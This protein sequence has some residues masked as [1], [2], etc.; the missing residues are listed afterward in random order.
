MCKWLVAAFV[1]GGAA[2][3]LTFPSLVNAA[4]LYF[5]KVFVK[6]NSEST[7]FR[8][9]GD[10]ARLEN[11]QNVHK[12]ALEVAGTKNG[13][14]VSI[15]CVGRGNQPAVAIVMSVADTLEVAKHAADLA[16]NR[17]KG[18]VCFDSPC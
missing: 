11:F 15:T 16:A 13:A 8:F 4:A 17:I 9:A 18:I 7:C 1:A 14:Y 5:D 2:F 3:I 6:T 12:N 10:T